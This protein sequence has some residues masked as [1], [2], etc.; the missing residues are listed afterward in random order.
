MDSLGDYIYLIIL[1]VAGLSSLLKKKKKASELKPAP[2]EEDDE[3][4]TDWEDVIRN[5]IPESPAEE[6]KEFVPESAAFNPIVTYETVE[7]VSVMRAKKQVSRNTTSKKK[8]F[9][10]DNVST[11]NIIDDIQLNTV[12]DARKAFIYSE[13]FNKKY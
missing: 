11:P 8:I 10:E 5:L 6:K 2:V 9:I 3:P 1:V 12:D 13:I 7:D 4:Q